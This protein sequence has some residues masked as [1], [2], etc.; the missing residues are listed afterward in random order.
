MIVV[1]ELDPEKKTSDD[2][3]ETHL[4]MAMEERKEMVSNAGADSYIA[5]QPRRIDAWA[6]HKRTPSSGRAEKGRNQRFQHPT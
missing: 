3:R 2:K 6:F 4:P 1:D 5:R